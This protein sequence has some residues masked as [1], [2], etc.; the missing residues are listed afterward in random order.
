ML[1]AVKNQLRVIM[2]TIKYGLMR[3]MINKTSFIMNIAFMILNNASFI[4]QWWIYI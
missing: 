4:I 1:Q 2:K 3:E